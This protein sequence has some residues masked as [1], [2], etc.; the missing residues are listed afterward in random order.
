M[1][2][3]T[4]KQ[5][6]LRKAVATAKLIL[7]QPAAMQAV[8]QKKVPKG[9]VFEFSRAA[10]LLAIKKTAELIPDCHPIPIEMAAIRFSTDAMTILIEVEVHTVY[11]TGV[12]VEAMHG[13]S[14][15]ALTMY[16]MLKPLDKEIEISS[17]RL[18]HKS[19]GKSNFLHPVP[20]NIRAAVV[21]CSDRV[22][23]GT[24]EDKSGSAIIEKLKALGLDSIEY[25]IIPDDRH[26]IEFA[27]MELLK[28][29]VDLIIF[30]GER[31]YQRG[32]SPQI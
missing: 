31:A 21:V 27:V 2:D 18:S 26:A 17:I 6:T 1:I 29:P 16:D 20:D 22:A 4:A 28:Q 23:A 9:D 25:R 19:G 30:T 24:K 14:V 32:I 13:A 3:I 15:V 11:K 5:Y 8:L 7:Q 10:G 12:E